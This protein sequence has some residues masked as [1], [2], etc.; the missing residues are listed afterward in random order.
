M[1]LAILVRRTTTADVPFFSF[2]VQ[3]GG[4]NERKI[5]KLCEYAAKNPLRIPKVRDVAILLRFLGLMM[6]SLEAC[7]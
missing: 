2:L 7:C 4:P 3:D 1:Y 6:H 5:M